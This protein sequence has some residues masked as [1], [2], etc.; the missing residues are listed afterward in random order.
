MIIFTYDTGTSCLS[1]ADLVAWMDGWSGTWWIIRNIRDLRFSRRWGQW[2]CSSGF[3][4]RVDLSV[5]T[6]V[7][8]KHAVSI[9][10][11]ERFGE[12]YCLHL[13]TWRWR[14]FSET[15]VS[16]DDS[17]PTF[18]RNIRSPS[19]ALKMEMFLRNV[20]IYQRVYTDVS[21][22]HTV[23][24]FVFSPEDGDSMFLRNVG[25]YRRVYTA[26]K[27]RTAA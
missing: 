12:T 24:I 19:S 17:T 18:R 21:G 9:F 2:W 23:S 5:D 26:Q 20:G 10:S 7:S 1:I 4:D 6:R 8:E 16:T 15:L 22:K 3:W 13:Q 27:P 14:C 11:P 25:T